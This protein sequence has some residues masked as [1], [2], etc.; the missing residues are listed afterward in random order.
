MI[1]PDRIEARTHQRLIG[2]NKTY[3][4][5][6][7][8]QIPDQWAQ[9]EYDKITGVVGDDVYGVSHGFAPESRFDY[10]CGLPVTTDAPVP[11]GQIALDIPAGDCAV[12][13]HDGHVSGIGPLF[14]AIICG[15][16]PG[17]GW[18]FCKGPQVELYGPEHDG[19]TG[20]GR[21]E[22]WMPVSRIQ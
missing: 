20:M 4:M 14:D 15:P 10:L 17:A 21:V 13:V 7:R 9:W 8:D 19:L 18:R 12:Y 22:I 11:D 6:T 3:S 1:T 16:G 2:S 5:A